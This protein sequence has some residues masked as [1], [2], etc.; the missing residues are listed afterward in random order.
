MFNI[1]SDVPFDDYRLNRQ[2]MAFMNN[3]KSLE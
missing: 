3:S 1:G 2:F